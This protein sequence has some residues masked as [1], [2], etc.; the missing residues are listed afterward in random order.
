MALSA[1]DSAFFGDGVDFQKAG[2]AF[3]VDTS[4]LK[5][6]AAVLA[7]V[8]DH[9]AIVACTYGKGRVI[10]VLMNP[11]GNIN[12]R[13]ESDTRGIVWLHRIA[14]Q[15]ERAVWINPDPVRMW[16][17]SQTCRV[18]SRLFPMFHLSVDGI[19]EAVTALVA[20]KDL[21]PLSFCCDIDMLLRS[22]CLHPGRA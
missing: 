5:D 13:H 14:A 21:K 17:S 3:C 16:S 1:A 18:I 8:G 15:F 7:K 10:T 22:E 9:P 6:G 2:Q 19:A 11:H 20:M 4:P 12:P